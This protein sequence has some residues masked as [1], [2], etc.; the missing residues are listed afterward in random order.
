VAKPLVFQNM[1]FVQLLKLIKEIL[2]DS[3]FELKTESKNN[4]DYRK[5]VK[6]CRKKRRLL[7]IKWYR[8]VIKQIH[9]STPHEMKQDIEQQGN[10]AV[11]QIIDFAHRQSKEQ[12]PL[13][14]VDLEKGPNNKDIF[15]I[16][17][18]IFQKQI[19]PTS[20]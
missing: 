15:Q 4:K 17:I 16:I 18:F 19:S 11:R 10:F 5:A 3:Q 6:V 14:F 7:P 12:L 1:Q 2:P 20:R 9:P 13:H 8:I